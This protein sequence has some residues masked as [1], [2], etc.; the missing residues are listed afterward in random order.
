MKFLKSLTDMLKIIIQ[1][2]NYCGSSLMDW[3]SLIISLAQKRTYKK[4]G[5]TNILV[6]N[7]LRLQ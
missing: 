2:V 6:R 1:L 5:I 3:K 7:I 4:L